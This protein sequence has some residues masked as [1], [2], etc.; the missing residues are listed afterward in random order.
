MLPVSI[1][2]DR[3]KARLV[4][5]GLSPRA[6]SLRA[7]TSADAIR[8]ILRGLSS[9]PKQ[10]TLRALATALECDVR[11]LVGEIDEHGEA[12]PLPGASEIELPIRYETAAGAWQAADEVEVQEP[13]MAVATRFQPYEQYRQW[14]ERVR[15]DS[16]NKL[17]PDGA[18]VQVV[19][20]I[21]M[22][23]EPKHDDVVIVQRTRA[24][25]SFLE[26]SLKQVDRTSGGILLCP[27]SHNPKWKEPLTL[28]DGL[29]EHETD[30]TVE[31][32]GKVLR[33]YIYLD[34]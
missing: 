19:D 12:A 23:Y 11:Y 33:A 8:N 9:S 32:V 29:G 34:T 5:L 24:Q 14:M 18:L 26:R 31:I 4:A 13:E 27:R 16:F 1:L 20:A 7:G 3:I 2:Q 30:V 6:A 22:G 10:S 15:G 17:I 28:G 25:G 21:E